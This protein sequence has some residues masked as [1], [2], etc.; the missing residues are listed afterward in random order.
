M[1]SRNQPVSTP[2]LE[3]N[4]PLVKPVIQKQNPF[5]FVL[6]VLVIVLLGSTGY[7]AFQNVKLQ[8]EIAGMKVTTHPSTPTTTSDPTAGW[9]TYTNSQFNISFKYPNDQDINEIDN[10]QNAGQFVVNMKSGGITK[11]NLDIQILQPNH[12]KYYLSSGPPDKNM[13]IGQMTWDI[14]IHGGQGYCDAGGCTGAFVTW[15]IIKDQTRFAFSFN[16]TD[17][18]TQEQQNLISTFQFTNQTSISNWKTY[19]SNLGNYTLKYPPD[20]YQNE[21]LAGESVPRLEL[22]PVQYKYPQSGQTITVFVYDNPNN[23]SIDQFEKNQSGISPNWQVQNIAGLQGERSQTLPGQ[24]ENDAVFVKKD[25]KI[26]ELI[27]LKAPGTQIQIDIFNQ[28][29]STFQFTK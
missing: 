27:L 5:L 26:Y 15:Q 16:G 9:K 7:L 20:W 1:D 22:S 18:I 6:V 24:F 3:P 19:N 11:V 17:Q 10:V 21:Y 12:S 2:A 29:L 23:L 8:K 25:N 4:Q 13:I 28:I 14:L